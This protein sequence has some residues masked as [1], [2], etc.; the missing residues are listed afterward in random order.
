MMQRFLFFS[1]ALLVSGSIF[2]D[3]HEIKRV[4][5]LD[6]SQSNSL[7]MQLCSLKPGKKMKDYE[8]SFDACLLYTSDAADE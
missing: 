4:A 5:G 7:Q 2:A 6:L 1:L 8:A 3:G